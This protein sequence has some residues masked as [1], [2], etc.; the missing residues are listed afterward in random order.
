M[1]KILTIF[2]FFFIIIGHINLPTCDSNN[3][4]DL[5]GLMEVNFQGNKFYK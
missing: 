4:L 3:L 2:I 1:D 5:F